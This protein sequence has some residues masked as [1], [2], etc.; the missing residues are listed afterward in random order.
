MRDVFINKYLHQ[1]L[2]PT[3]SLHAHGSCVWLSACLK[4]PVTEHRGKIF[5]MYL[6]KKETNIENLTVLHCHGIRQERIQ[7][8]KPEYFLLN[9]TVGVLT[10][11]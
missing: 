4:C 6:V 7:C 5:N 11:M 8:E 1:I 10:H 2:L 3:V 9:I